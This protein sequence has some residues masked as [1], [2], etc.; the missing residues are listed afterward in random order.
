MNEIRAYRFHSDEVTVATWR[1]R[2]N[3]VAFECHSLSDSTRSYQREHALLLVSAF[4]QWQFHT[5]TGGGTQAPKS[6]LG[7]QI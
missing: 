3:N 1:V 7:P 4:C 5:G 6:W 2:R